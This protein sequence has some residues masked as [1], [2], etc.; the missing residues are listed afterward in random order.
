MEG[1]V[2]KVS[3]HAVPAP[4]SPYVVLGG[5]SVVRALVD[6][7]YDIMD[8]N[9]DASA[10][11]AMHPAHLEDSRDKLYWYLS[12]WL[13][14]PQLFV[15]R[16]GHPRLRARH[17]PFAIDDAAQSAWMMCMTQAVH[18]VFADPVHRTMLLEPLS[19]LALHMRNQ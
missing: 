2:S 11:R 19:K 6:R 15:E 18:D 3:D 1:N 13:G 12:G 16:K 7:F 4:D 8:T 10:L 5:D 17:L 9:A 14:G